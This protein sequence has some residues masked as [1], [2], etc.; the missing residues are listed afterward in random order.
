MNYLNDTGLS[1]KA[2]GLLAWMLAHWRKRKS[3]S[4]TDLVMR[5]RD[6]IAAVQSGLRELERLGYLKREQPR[7]GGRL[8]AGKWHISARAGT[9]NQTTRPS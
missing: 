6:R 9:F 2:R 5:G 7:R 3:I 1:W 8:R 4:V